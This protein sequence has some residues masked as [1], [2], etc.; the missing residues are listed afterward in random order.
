MFGD[1]IS[2]LTTNRNIVRLAFSLKSADK[3]RSPTYE[4]TSLRAGSGFMQL[5]RLLFLDAGADPSTIGLS[6]SKT[7]LDVSLRM[8]LEA[9]AKSMT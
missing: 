8:Q 2:I 3:P 6:T 5:T 4:M 1:D 7:D 9:Y